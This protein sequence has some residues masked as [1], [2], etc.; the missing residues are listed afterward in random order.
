MAGSFTSPSGSPAKMKHGR[1]H[2]GKDSNRQAAKSEYPITDKF[3][4][5]SI[6]GFGSR[7]AHTNAK[8]GFN[9]VP[10]RPPAGRLAQRAPT[11]PITRGVGKEV[12]RREAGRAANSH[13]TGGTQRK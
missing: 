8:S 1:G 6:P 4:S 11:Q 9:V 10:A 5:N 2:P 12:R 3:A 7:R 13:D